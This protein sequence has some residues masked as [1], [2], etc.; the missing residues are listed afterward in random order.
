MGCPRLLVASSAEDRVLSGF[1][2]SGLT[3]GGEDQCSTCDLLVGRF[4]DDAAK[5]PNV[6]GAAEVPKANQG[7]AAVDSVDDTF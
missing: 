7:D 1:V 4:G 6:G 2:R 3:D 5:D